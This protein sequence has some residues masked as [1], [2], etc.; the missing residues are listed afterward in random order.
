MPYIKTTTNVK[1]PA[2]TYEC[3]KAEFAEAI[4]LFPGKSEAWL[5]V[6]FEDETPMYF[7]G[8]PDP[9]AMVEV[10]LFGSVQPAAADAMSA[11]VCAFLGEELGIDP[12]RIYIKYSGTE[13]WGWNGHNF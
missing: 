5:M 13:N 3:L 4:E 11:R 10:N 7:K 12:A 1:I 9:C 6:A 2:P 8:S